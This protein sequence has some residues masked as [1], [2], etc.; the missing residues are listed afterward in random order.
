[1]NSRKVNSLEKP[2]YIFTLKDPLKTTANNSLTS[3]SLISTIFSIFYNKKKEEF[4]L[5]I[6]YMKYHVIN[7]FSIS[8][9]QV[10]YK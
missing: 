5:I 4:R 8:P 6:I 9:K 10:I 3:L 1:M 2:S 7:A